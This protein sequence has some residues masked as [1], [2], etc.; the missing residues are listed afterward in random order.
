MAEDTRNCAKCGQRPAGAGRILC[1]DCKT[2]LE[3]RAHTYWTAHDTTGL[4][5][6]G[7]PTA[8]PGTDH[9]VAGSAINDPGDAGIDPA[10]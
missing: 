4:Q 5:Q 1:P 7:Q 2:L 6:S 10:P 8:T 3:H 9:Q